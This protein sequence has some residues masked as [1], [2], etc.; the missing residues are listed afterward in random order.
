MNDNPSRGSLLAMTGH[1]VLAMAEGTT[2]TLALFGSE[3]ERDAYLRA[4]FDDHDIVFVAF[5]LSPAEFSFLSVKGDRWLASEFQPPPGPERSVTSLLVASFEE[6]VRL[7]MRYG[8]A[9][10]RGYLPIL[11]PSRIPPTSR[12]RTDDDLH[13]SAAEERRQRRAAKRAKGA[14]RG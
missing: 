10:A 13:L 5:W 2:E 3:G 1:R 11:T 7:G 6:A 14:A 4:L 8:D 9:D 12:F